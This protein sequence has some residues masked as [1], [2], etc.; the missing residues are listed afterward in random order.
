MWASA[1]GL[2][3]WAAAV[4]RGRETVAFR[5]ENIMIRRWGVSASGRCFDGW[6]NWLM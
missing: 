2:E 3:E 6:F 4:R 1:W 5:A